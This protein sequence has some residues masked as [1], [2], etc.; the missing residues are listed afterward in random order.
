MLTI[1]EG[2]EAFLVRREADPRLFAV[3]FRNCLI[4]LVREGQERSYIP[5]AW[6]LSARHEGWESLTRSMNSGNAR[7]MAER[8]GLTR[9]SRDDPKHELFWEES[10]AECVELA[11]RIL[12]P[13]QQKFSKHLGRPRQREDNDYYLLSLS[14]DSSSNIAVTP[15]EAFLQPCFEGAPH[16]VTTNRYER[17]AKLR[18]DFMAFFRSKDAG[19]L[20]CQACYHDFEAAYGAI[21]GGFIHIHHKHPLG[22]KQA[23]HE[24]DPT[25]DLVPVCPNCHAMIHRGGQ[26]R[27]IAEIRKLLGKVE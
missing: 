9:I 25:R 5:L 26:N 14:T 10:V 23:E 1:A 11:R 12:K 3:N 22:N 7:A 17:K 21:G 15:E 27:S 4:F 20:L 8:A 6:A 19:R 18:E 24:V 2:A 16:Q 13:H